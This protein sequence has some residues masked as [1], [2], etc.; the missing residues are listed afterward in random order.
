MAKL[1]IY[2]R[3]GKERH[4]LALAD[5]INALVEQLISEEQQQEERIVPIAEDDNNHRQ[6]DHHSN[7]S[8]P[9]HDDENDQQL[10]R[11]DASSTTSDPHLSSTATSQVA[12][13]TGHR[14]SS[15]RK[16]DIKGP[17]AFAL[18]L[19]ADL[20]RDQDEPNS[21]DEEDGTLAG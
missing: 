8:Q 17:L 1:K 20:A 3:S 12:R 13:E 10:S 16:G 18:E 11:Q 14:P 9:R 2:S 21:D 5:Q 15:L 4:P 19:E 7:E 6:Q